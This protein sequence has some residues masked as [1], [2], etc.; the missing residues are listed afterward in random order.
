MNK[1]LL[2][3]THNGETHTIREWA[4]ITGLTDRT[5]RWRYNEGWPTD[6]ILDPHAYRGRGP[7]SRETRRPTMI[8]FEG[9]TLTIAEWAKVVGLKESTLRNRLKKGWEIKRALMT[10]YNDVN[11]K[12]NPSHKKRCAKC[13]FSNRMSGQMGPLYCD[14]L[15]KQWDET[16]APHRRPCPPEACTVFEPKKR[17][18]QKQEKPYEWSHGTWGEKGDRHDNHD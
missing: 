3:I 8:T 6:M 7:D 5:I 15:C 10:E 11:P 16:G 9:R 4:K 2:T 18:K 13:R 1:Q 17:G 14:Y 12:H